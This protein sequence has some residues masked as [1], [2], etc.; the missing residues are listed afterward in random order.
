MW[1]FGVCQLVI[2]TE[3]TMKTCSISIFL[4]RARTSEKLAINRYQS[5]NNQIQERPS[6]MTGQE[7]DENV[8]NFDGLEE[9]ES[10]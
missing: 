9:L 6:D 10:R 2:L 4:A 3:L 5:T 8:E 7:Q 1:C